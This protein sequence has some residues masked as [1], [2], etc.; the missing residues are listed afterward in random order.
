MKAAV[1]ACI[2]LGCAGAPARP[3]PVEQ[4]PPP[5]SPAKSETFS[6][7]QTYGGDLDAVDLSVDERL[8]WDYLEDRHDIGCSMEP[9]LVA[10][11]REH[12]ELL[13]GEG[14]P[15][16][17]GGL[18]RVRFNLMRRG[19]Y[20][21]RVST[22]VARF[23]T[24]S[25]AFEGLAESLFRRGGEGARR[26]SH[27]G[28][29]VARGQRGAFAVWLHTARKL[30]LLPV[31]ARPR[32]FEQVL[33]RARLSPGVAGDTSA[34]WATPDG[35]VRELAGTKRGRE[36]HFT[37]CPQRPGRH[38]LELTFNPGHGPETEVLVQ[39]F[40]DTEPPKRP[41]VTPS[42]DGTLSLRDAEDALYRYID[43]SR[44]HAG[45]GGLRRDSRLDAVARRHSENMAD[46]EY[47]GHIDPFK[48]ALSARLLRAGID[49]KKAA[50]NVAQSRSA[51]RI[52]RNLMASPSHRIHIISPEFTHVGIGFARGKDELIATEIFARW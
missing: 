18:D 38:E 6:W 48:G 22:V 30:E 1:A 44:R 52:H 34:F 24:D 39:L 12:A 26:A 20:D 21:Y 49:V 29:G 19:G 40:V 15:K 27:C 3:S 50:E 31:P 36:E 32:V 37:V 23:Q 28:L 46:K 42:A 10:V 25:G 8:I 4:A 51:L 47:F 7:T 5:K 11:A 9:R 45:V 16:D 41:V 43:N 13:A 33:V 14:R 35:R 17:S 2:L